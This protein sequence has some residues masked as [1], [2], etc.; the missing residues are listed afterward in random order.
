MIQF[1]SVFLCQK[2]GSELLN[3]DISMRDFVFFFFFFEWNFNGWKFKL[4]VD[5]D[6]LLQS[7]SVFAWLTFKPGKHAREIVTEHFCLLYTHECVKCI[8]W[9]IKSWRSKTS[10]KL[11]NHWRT[12]LFLIRS[13]AHSGSFRKFYQQQFLNHFSK[14]Y[15]DDY[16]WTS[17]MSRFYYTLR[18]KKMLVIG[19][20][21][22]CFKY[23]FPV[24][25]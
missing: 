8:K 6:D 2:L 3:I 1:C 20:N 5:L 11:Y 25:S 14:Q 22:C 13:L 17:C 7:A 23:Y 24:L 21:K 18:K 19:N 4:A 16:F 15:L 9:K 12:L 10:L